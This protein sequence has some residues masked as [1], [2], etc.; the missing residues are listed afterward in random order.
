M[1]IELIDLHPAPADLKQLVQSGFK[2]QP[3]QLPAW[4]LYDAKGSRLFAQIC[5]QP[6]YG[7]TRTAVSYTHLTLPT[8][9]LV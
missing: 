5:E 3:R 6:E 7:L 9:L 8:I 4:V 1:S 2:C